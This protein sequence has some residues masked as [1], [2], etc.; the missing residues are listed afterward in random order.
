MKSIGTKPD[1]ILNCPL[2]TG[3]KKEQVPALLKCLGAQRRIFEKN[4]DVFADEQSVRKIGV[5]LK[6]AVDIVKIDFW[7]NRSILSRVAAGGLFGEAFA[8]A[9]LLKP[10]VAAVASEQSEIL[11]LQYQKIFGTCLQSCAYHSLLLQNMM[12]VLAEKNILLTRKMEHITKRSTRQKLLSYLSEQ[13]ELSGSSSF[14]IPFNRQ[15]LADFLS[16]DRSAMSNELCKL[17]GEGM[18][19]FHKNSFV[20]L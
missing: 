1:A 4:Q 16:V 2:F 9:G 10:P 15:E 11:L 14:T 13:A 8:C 3:V 6:G 20:L 18:L 5:V 7:G 19:Q 17:R 12:K